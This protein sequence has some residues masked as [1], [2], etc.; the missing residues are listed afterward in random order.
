MGLPHWQRAHEQTQLDKTD[1]KAVRDGLEVR[2]VEQPDGEPGERYVLCRSGARAEN[3]RAMLRHRSERLTAELIKIYAWQHRTPQTDQEKVGRRIGRH[4]DQYPAAAAIVVAEVLRDGEGRAAGLPIGSRLDAGKKAHRQR[5][6]YLLRTNCE[7]TDPGLLWK[8]YIQ[9]TQAEAAFRT[10]KS[11]LRL[12]PVFH[13]KEDRVQPHILV[14]FLA[15]A[16]WRTLEQWMHSKGLGTRARQ[17]VREV[18]GI[19]CVDVV[20]PVRRAEITTELRLRVVTTPK[21]TAAQLLA[22]L[23]LRLPKGTRVISNV[24]PEN[25]FINYARASI[26]IKNSSELR[27][28]G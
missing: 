10:A 22:N 8:W 9:L 21:P 13:H 14:C 11:D 5:G 12:R 20:V 6:A 3:E 7:E 2:L 25:H 16:L 28:S 4:L 27:N 23:G 24:V 17:L 19:K 1:W 26:T 15:L 18:A